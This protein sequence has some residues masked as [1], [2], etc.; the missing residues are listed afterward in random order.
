LYVYGRCRYLR[1]VCDKCFATSYAGAFFQLIIVLMGVL[2]MCNFIVTWGFGGVGFM[3][4]YLYMVLFCMMLHYFSVCFR[5]LLVVLCWIVVIYYEIV[6]L[7]EVVY[8]MFVFLLRE[9]NYCFSFVCF[10]CGKFIC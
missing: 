3:S 6:V 7:Y 9:D 5:V 1:S 4:L 2:G 10:C 8:F